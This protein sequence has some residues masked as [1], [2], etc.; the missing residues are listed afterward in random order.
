MEPG[1]EQERIIQEESYLVEEHE[2]FRP[3][4]DDE[5][6]QEEGTNPNPYLSYWEK[7]K[8][9]LSSSRVRGKE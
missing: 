3:G 1:S 6:F 5:H 7:R 4:E 8:A 9:N 2:K